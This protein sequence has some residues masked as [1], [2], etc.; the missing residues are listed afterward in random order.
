M[1]EGALEAS[2]I[3][4]EG[5]FRERA[6]WDGPVMEGTFGDG[7]ATSTGALKNGALWDGVVGGAAFL[8]RPAVDGPARISILQFQ[9]CLCQRGNNL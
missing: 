7:D 8:E 9:P 5:V 3:A 4:R 2:T 6:F 1:G